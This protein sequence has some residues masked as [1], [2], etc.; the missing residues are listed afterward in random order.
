MAADAQGN[1]ITAVAVPVTGFIGLAPFGTEFPTPVEGA[2][3]DLALDVAFKRLGLLKDDGGPQWAWE[4]DGDAVEFWQDGYSIPSGLANV[5][6]SATAAQT[7]PFTRSVVSGK[8][9]DANGYITVD[10]G[11]HATQYVLFTEEIFKNGSIRRRVAP[12][13]RVESVTEDQSTRGEVLGYAFT[14]SVRRSPLVN[15]EHFGEWLVLP[16]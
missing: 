9:P 2:D 5:T 1:D 7:D 14:F 11:G 4:P 16:A 15:N 6:V 12:N 10:G 3:P 8:T 13:V